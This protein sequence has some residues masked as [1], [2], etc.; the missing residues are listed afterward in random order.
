MKSKLESLFIILIML[1]SIAN[2][3]ICT[4]AIMKLNDNTEKTYITQGEIKSKQ[5]LVT[6]EYISRISPKTEVESFVMQLGLDNKEIA[7]FEDET[8]EIKVKEGLISTGMIMTVRN[9]R[10]EIENIDDDS[11]QDENEELDNVEETQEID[12][13]LSVVGDINQDGRAN[14][15]EVVQIINHIVGLEGKEIEGIRLV[16]SDV[17]GDQKID[18]GDICKLIK[19]IVFEE[20][21]IG[22]VGAPKEPTIEVEGNEKNG[23]Y[24]EDTIVSILTQEEEFEK[25]VYSIDGEKFE[26]AS[27]EE[28]KTIK[29]EGTHE[30]EAY[31]YGTIGNKSLLAETEIKIDKQGPI[32]ENINKTPEVE[33][34]ETVKIEIV[35]KDNLSGIEEEGYSFDGGET[36]QKENYKEY[37]DNVEEIKIQ[38]KD[39]A[40][41]IT[42]ET[43]SIDNIVPEKPKYEVVFK[44]HDGTV[45][46]IEEVEEGNVPE[47]K[48]PIPV[49]SEDNTYTYEFIGWDKEVVNA[50]EN[51]EYV[52]VF[53][54]IYKNYT[55]VFKNE[56]G[57]V[58]SSKED[59]HYGDIVEV[60]EEPTKAEDNTYTY[61]FVGWDKEITEV[62]GNVEYTAKYEAIYKNYT[63]VFKNEDGSVIS[64]KEDYHYGDTI[65]IPEIPQKEKI[66][67]N[68]TFAG[69]GKEVT[70]VKE[71]V[72][73][74]AEFEELAIEYKI[75][76]ELNGGTAE[77]NPST[78]N[79]E[80]ETFKLNNPSK[81]YYKFLGWT[82]NEETEVKEEVLIEKGSIGDRKYIANWELNVEAVKI[83]ETGIIYSSIEL[84]QEKVENGQTIIILQ[85]LEENVVVPEGMNIVLDLNGKKISNLG[86]K[87]PTI[88]N[89]GTLT[90]ID[91][92][93]E[94]TGEIENIINQTIV[95]EKNALL[96][97]G[98]VEDDVFT[99]PY[100]NGKQIGIK[101]EGT[102]NFYDGKVEGI[103]AIQGVVNE[104][105]PK[106]NMVMTKKEVEIGEEVESREVITLGLMADSV[107]RIDNLYYTSIEKAIESLEIKGEEIPEQNQ[108]TITMLKDV[109]VTNQ[110]IV[111]EYMNIRIDLNNY[112]VSSTTNGENMINNAG[113]LEITDLSEEKTGKLTSTSVNTLINNEEEAELKITGGT[114]SSE[115]VGTTS[116][117]NNIIN[118]NGELEVTGGTISS[119]VNY[120]YLILNNSEA[121]ISGGTLSSAYY[122]IYNN[123]EF[124]I[125]ECAIITTNAHAIINTGNLLIDNTIY[126]GEEKI[127]EKELL[128]SAYKGISNINEGKINIKGGTI[129]AVYEAIGHES[130]SE[131]IIEGGY[132]KTSQYTK[133]SGGSSSS[134]YKLQS[135]IR[136][137]G[138]GTMKILGG[139]IEG[140]Y[141]G[142]HNFGTNLEISGGSIYG[143]YCGV[144]YRTT[145]A[146]R[147]TGGHIEGDDKGLWSAKNGV[148]DI[149]GGTIESTKGV[150]I[151]TYYFD[152]PRFMQ[153]SREYTTGIVRIGNN[154]GIVNSNEEDKNNCPI[155]KGVS[156]GIKNDHG[157]IEIYDGI[158][159]ANNSSENAIYGSVSEIAEGYDV[160]FND[161]ETD[162]ENGI[163]ESHFV[164]LTNDPVCKI[165]ETG[166]TYTSVENALKEIEIGNTIQ[167]IK[168]TNYIGNMIEITEEK[169]VKIDLNGCK[170][171]VGNPETTI[172]NNGVLEILDSSEEKIGMII[173]NRCKQIIINKGKLTITGG[174]IKNNKTYS[175]DCDL[176]LNYDELI[177]N[178]GQL[179]ATCYYRITGGIAIKN[180]G[181]VDLA[182]GT[183]KGYRGIYGYE[184][185]TLNIFGGKIETSYEA[186][187]HNST[188]DI[189]ITAGEIK[190]TSYSYDTITNAST[191]EISIEGGTF[192]G[193]GYLINNSGN[194][195]ITIN[196]VDD[197]ELNIQSKYA[198]I[199]NA[200]GEV[201]IN[202]AELNS[203]GS[204]VISNTTGTVN[205]ANAILTGTSSIIS[206]TTGTVN[207]DGGKI[208]AT[209]NHNTYSGVYNSGT[210]IV[211]IIDGEIISQKGYG[212]TNSGGGT[213]VLG[214]NDKKVYPTNYP[215]E[216][217]EEN[218]PIV[219]GITYGI[220]NTKG[221]IEFYD[222]VIFVN[223]EAKDAIYGTV[224]STEKVYDEEG[225][226]T[227]EYDILFK[228]IE[229][230]EETGTEEM[231]YAMLGNEPV[232]AILNEEGEET[233]KYI[234]LN[235]AI[236]DAQENYTIKILRS[237]NYKEKIVI[238]ESKSIKIDLNGEK[239]TAV[240]VVD[241]NTEDD[242][243]FIENK[244]TLEIYDSSEGKTGEITST[245]RKI[246]IDNKGTIKEIK[247]IEITLQTSGVKSQYNYAI[248]NS[249]K[250]ENIENAKIITNAQY[251]YLLYNEGTVTSTNTEINS[252]STQY[253]RPIYNSESSKLVI[254]GGKVL[255]NSS[256]SWDDYYLVSAIMNYGELEVNDS[257]ICGYYGITNEANAIA[258]INGAT[259]LNGTVNNKQLGTVTVNGGTINKSISNYGEFDINDGIF[260]ESISNYNT[261]EMNLVKGSFR[262]ISNSGNLVIEKDVI[263][264]YT[265]STSSAISN[266]NTGNLVVNGG[267][268]KSIMS[269]Y[270]HGF[271]VTNSGQF[272]WNDGEFYCKTEFV[273]GSITS[274]PQGKE[275]AKE[276]VIIDNAEFYKYYLQDQ[277]ESVAI[278]DTKYNSLEDALCAEGDTKEIKLLKD[279]IILNNIEIGE[280]QNITIDLAGY[281]LEGYVEGYLVN[282]KGI[283]NLK[284]SSTVKSKVTTP[285][286]IIENSNN[287]TLENF[288]INI[289]CEGSSN[290][291][292]NTIYNNGEKS[293]LT[294]N[295]II[296]NLRIAFP[297]A[298]TNIINNNKGTINLNGGELSSPR[299]NVNL[300]VNTGKVVIDGGK[301]GQSVYSIVNQE[302]GDI[303]INNIEV[304]YAGSINNKEKSTMTINGGIFTNTSIS[305]STTNE[306]LI[307]G[308]N[309]SSTGSLISNSSGTI[310]IKGGMFE[311]SG[312]NNISNGSAG[313]VN[314]E[315]GTFKSTSSSS[316]VISNNSTGTINIKGGT[317]LHTTNS[318]VYNSSTGTINIGENDS[319]EPKII[320]EIKSNS[321]Y[322]VY[323]NNTSGIINFYDGAI[324]GKLGAVYGT[325]TGLPEGYGI[326]KEIK[327]IELIEGLE[328]YTLEKLG[329]DTSEASLNGIYYNSLQDAINAATGENDVIILQRNIV[330]EE[331]Q[332]IEIAANQIVTI[333]LNGFTIEG[334]VINDGTLTIMNSKGNIDGNYGEVTGDGTT[335]VQQPNQE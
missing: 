103:K 48:A 261:G 132:F 46:Q 70:V 318:A 186:I 182:G 86:E 164:I 178:G 22:E 140:C 258:T 32:I 63:V 156:Y 59:Y 267:S 204:G 196:K 27:R 221:N 225:N 301:L 36:W 44:N 244:G 202:N 149:I 105:A 15:V 111:E 319:E 1:L 10:E 64:S 159:Y 259:I 101:N 285:Y 311:S 218:Y 158:I 147:I 102:L 92:S 226:I 131:V 3:K 294:T 56:N 172:S 125:N 23:W 297:W 99:S 268:A 43:V 100:I 117:Y 236:E 304:A 292:S 265:G 274:I 144:N 207:I 83:K 73:Y 84:A 95:N 328:L 287:A 195:A 108:S 270:D 116:V 237:I 281:D 327:T 234:N 79:I 8:K 246:L 87:A 75:T 299:D 213:I 293:I 220:Y 136:N 76:Y 214:E 217:S 308:G 90:I 279:L 33:T 239:I 49:K 228:D 175:E 153:S 154:D 245:T 200:S 205:L 60:P 141:Y 280:G 302:T 82:L 320:P 72:E 254:K 181:K 309:F 152:E 198:V 240:Y 170:V 229:A 61:K 55:V 14:I 272:E 19:Y 96:N 324:I 206:N 81:E 326:K 185:S 291:Y 168:D 42:E 104:V 11:M 286:K 127:G 41:N 145:N 253:S 77:G 317:I 306:L 325:I 34:T 179:E 255:G 252:S 89:K 193:A 74:I 273:E 98:N 88:L 260:N 271:V 106:Y 163:E 282:N 4:D 115:K 50:T 331:G 251:I 91:S 224:S 235:K 18:I 16:S 47:Y 160:K 321:K 9:P 238:D 296:I 80:T 201:N 233:A 315:G 180:Y 283:F 97:I 146:M 93:E 51:V 107:A 21:E 26:T 126:D 176:I 208:E 155:I 329:T 12:Y 177:I 194:G 192:V 241:E 263:I 137:A 269:Y 94:K 330:L 290:N 121:E 197:K 257:E 333:D 67:Y 161:I 264:N 262:F 119:N 66:G 54:P 249:G 232:C 71:D 227:G 20:L 242:G 323:N 187:N 37:T 189:N 162:E 113:K 332:K 130:K 123:G 24:K 190:N 184:D 118:N 129:D 222:G 7:I 289:L 216:N 35:A 335:N 314:I 31:T 247:D 40:G 69:W 276:K 298:Y 243:T 112:V 142:I 52:A 211:K 29:Q 188:G 288:S 45:L 210:G 174:T 133:E 39:I 316:Y 191:A 17:N 62:K 120:L 248:K 134:V 139:N 278:G 231:H 13:E 148:I 256:H 169:N 122:G 138:T 151:S 212:I 266:S 305:N 30:I 78:Y 203:T 109:V 28:E 199:K 157:K 334:S 300:L 110:I 277:T 38:V 5:Y 25:T 58:I 275:I 65:V 114:I 167:M 128:I 223:T 53:K 57:S 219:K 313:T 2:I 322:G 68:C 171:T 295:D 135:V 215:T 312:N 183:I 310:N 85:D 209:G 284:N 230:N 307:N 173:S 166:K 6:D 150:A 143:K 303:I 165:V 250:I 124:N